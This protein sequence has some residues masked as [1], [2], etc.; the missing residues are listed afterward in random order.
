MTSA[1]TDISQSAKAH[2]L[3]YKNSISSPPPS[4]LNSASQRLSAS[5][6]AMRRMQVT[7]GDWERKGKATGLQKGQ[8]ETG[9][10]RGPIGATSHWRRPL[11][12]VGAK[13]D[14]AIGPAL[15]IRGCASHAGCISYP[16][17]HPAPCTTQQLCSSMYRCHGACTTPLVNL[18]MHLL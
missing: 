14:S 10:G 4:D 15:S 5:H 8:D 2:T 16:A 7:M 12:R 17:L 11:S 3:V 1:A 18:W 9:P 13:R 6:S